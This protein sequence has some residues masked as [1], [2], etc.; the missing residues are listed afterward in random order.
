MDVMQKEMRIRQMN[1]KLNNKD[2]WKQAEEENETIED[3]SNTVTEEEVQK[4]IK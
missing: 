3:W 4:R 2:E 1:L